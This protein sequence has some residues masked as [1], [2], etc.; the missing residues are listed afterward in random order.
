MIIL[1]IAI[2]ACGGGDKPSSTPKNGSGTGAGHDDDSI[3]DVA[4][5]EG[6]PTLGGGG[7]GVGIAG[8]LRLELVDKD[9]PIHLD[10]T[11]KEWSLVPA[12]TVV[13][14]TSDTIAFKCGLAY[15]A[16]NVYFAG[17]VVGVKLRHL[18]RFTDDEDH[19]SLVIAAPSSPAVEVT[20]F[21][22][23]PGESAGVVRIHG[24]NVPG[25]KDHRGR[26]RQGLHVRSPGSVERH[27]SAQR[28]RGAPRGC[29][30]PRRHAHHPRDRLGRR[31]VTARHARA[32]HRVRRGARRVLP[33]AQ[34]S[35]RHHA[36]VRAPR[37]HTR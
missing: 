17:D 22:G 18:R 11:V 14:G 33:R 30:F 34:G 31:C 26:Q 12:R 21:P 28:P 20:F 15:D 9:N 29:A 1:A 10:G 8:S 5:R 36:E 23:K 35:P 4:S 32:A 24:Q 25:A 3:A 16:Q 7:Q 19:A 6:L 37:R 13:T 2:V 27:R